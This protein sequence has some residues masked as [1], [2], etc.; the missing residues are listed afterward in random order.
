[1]LVN[2]LTFAMYWSMSPCTKRLQ[3][4]TRS[5][6]SFSG[7]LFQVCA[8]ALGIQSIGA[9][10]D[11]PAATPVVVFRKSRRW[12]MVSPPSCGW[13]V[14]CD[15]RA[16][17]L[18]S[19]A[20]CCV[21]HVNRLGYRLEM[22]LRPGV[23]IVALAEHG[24]QFAGGALREHLGVGARG[25][26]DADLGGDAGAAERQVLGANPEDDVAAAAGAEARHRQAGAASDLD[27]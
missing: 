7:S 4:S 9:L 26:D 24:A 10:T 23:E 6:A 2:F 25:L 18:E 22:D 12:V 8:L 14:G 11:A 13:F 19:L 5:F 20:A 17:P 27:A 1:D 21:E 15:L 3:R 16:H